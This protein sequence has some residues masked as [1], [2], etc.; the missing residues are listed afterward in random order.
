MVGGQLCNIGYTIHARWAADRLESN[1][2]TET[3]L[4]E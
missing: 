4:W 1:C 2:I 3:H